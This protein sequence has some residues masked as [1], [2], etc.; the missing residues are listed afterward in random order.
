M[1]CCGIG[2]GNGTSWCTVENASNI[3]LVCLGLGNILFLAGAIYLMYTG[4]FQGK[5]LVASCEF[6]GLLLPN[7]F[8]NG[9][10][11]IMIF[12]ERICGTSGENK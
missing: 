4:N 10:F 6:W 7:I 3:E 12:K 2:S 5:A 1:T 11:F 9:S 8:M